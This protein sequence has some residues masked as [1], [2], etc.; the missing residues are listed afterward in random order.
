MIN[1]TFSA[2]AFPGEGEMR[3]GRCIQNTY[4]VPNFCF[5]YLKKN[6]KQ[7]YKILILDIEWGTQG[8]FYSMILL[9]I[10]NIYDFFKIKN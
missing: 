5:F 8:F 3:S 6:L 4:T 1:I 10:C 7:I 9:Y 2:V